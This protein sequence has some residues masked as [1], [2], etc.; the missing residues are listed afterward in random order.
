M[1]VVDEI[2]LL[3][4]RPL[5]KYSLDV[6][7]MGTPRTMLSRSAML[8]EMQFLVNNYNFRLSYSNRKKGH[9]SYFSGKHENWKLAMEVRIE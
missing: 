5:H 9:V 3:P 2:A 1:F 4:I 7:F 6:S 8:E